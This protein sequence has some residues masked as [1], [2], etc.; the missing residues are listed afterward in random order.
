MAVWWGTAVKTTSAAAP[1]TEGARVLA[2]GQVDQAGQGRKDLG[3]G[4]AGIFQRG[5]GRQLAARMPHQKAHQLQPGVTGSADN[6]NFDLVHEVRI[7]KV[8][9]QGRRVGATQWV[10]PTFPSPQ[11]P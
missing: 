1:I 8:I 10:A 4:A 11:N 9:I 6:G 7:I 5:K 3:K 2:E